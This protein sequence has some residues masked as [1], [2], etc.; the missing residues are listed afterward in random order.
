MA[1]IFTL[2]EDLEQQTRTQHDFA[3]EDFVVEY[4]GLL[5]H[6]SGHYSIAELQYK[7]N[8]LQEAQQLYQAAIA[9]K[10]CKEM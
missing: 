2:L 3:D 7:I 9:A 4:P 6:C 8:V 1:T 10:Q 5:I